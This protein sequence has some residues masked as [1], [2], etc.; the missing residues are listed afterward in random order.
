MIA[1]ILRHIL[2]ELIPYEQREFPEDLLAILKSQD[3]NWS[4]ARQVDS[5]VADFILP[6]CCL[7]RV[8]G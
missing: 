5:N 8:R 6:K 3:F 7:A 1:A 4:S 2:V